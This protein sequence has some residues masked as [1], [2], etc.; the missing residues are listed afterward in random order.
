MHVAEPWLSM[1][2]SGKKKIEGRRGPLSKFQHILESKAE[3]LLWNEAMGEHAVRIKAIRHYFDLY[4]Y[5]ASEGF[6]KAMPGAPS[7]QHVID[8]YHVFYSDAS[9]AEEGG[10]NA[11]ELEL[12][13]Q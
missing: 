2:L 8:A 6:E 11:L 12:I 9:I 7:L 4:S 5:L 10:M 1:I 13:K 3:L